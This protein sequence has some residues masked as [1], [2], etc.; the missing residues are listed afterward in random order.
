MFFYLTDM[1]LCRGNPEHLLY[2]LL[3][4][5]KGKQAEF[6]Q[7]SL[8]RCASCRQSGEHPGELEHRY[9]S[10]RC[11]DANGRRTAI[12]LGEVLKALPLFR[13]VLMGTENTVIQIGGSLQYRMKV[14]CRTSLKVV[15]V[16]VSDIL[17][18]LTG[19]RSRLT[20]SFGYFFLQVSA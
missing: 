16:G 10:K 8:S 2:A 14:C 6:V 20:T 15:V 11:C 13:A 5:V 9:F 1:R 18:I 12:Q 4:L 17:L 3:R 7:C 19:S